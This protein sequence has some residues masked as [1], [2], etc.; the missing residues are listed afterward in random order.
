MPSVLPHW[1]NQGRDQSWEWSLCGR[2]FNSAATPVL[3]DSLQPVLGLPLAVI[4]TFWV[5]LPVRL[6]GLN[7]V[8][9]G[10]HRYCEE[11]VSCW[12]HS[13]TVAGKRDRQMVLSN[14]RS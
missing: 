10:A 11:S 8:H 4:L 2:V 12:Y 1:R 7:P 13:D 14:P 9:R 3:Q 5:L 6:L